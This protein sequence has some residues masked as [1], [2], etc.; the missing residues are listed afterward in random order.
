MRS[1]FQINGYDNVFQIVKSK[2]GF[3][4]YELCK[5]IFCPFQVAACAAQKVGVEPPWEDVHSAYNEPRTKI[6]SKH[7]DEQCNDTAVRKSVQDR[8]L[9]G[10][11]LNKGD[12]VLCHVAVVELRDGGAFSVSARIGGEHGKTLGEQGNGAIE[13]VRR[14]A[15]AV[16]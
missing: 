11:R 2:V 4:D 12:D 5:R 6:G 8:L 13:D 3:G 15:V 1:F 9:N 16:Q 7:S 14:F 10:Q